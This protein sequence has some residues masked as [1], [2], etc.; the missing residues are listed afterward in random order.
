[1]LCNIQYFNISIIFGRYFCRNKEKDRLR[2][3]ICN[4]ICHKE[5]NCKFKDNTEEARCKICKKCGHEEKIV[6]SKEKRKKSWEE[7]N[8]FQQNKE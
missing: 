5:R 1:M 2:C 3:P 8:Y 6:G 7:K 4:I